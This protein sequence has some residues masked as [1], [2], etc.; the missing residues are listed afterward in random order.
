MTCFKRGQIIVLPHEGTDISAL[1]DAGIR[2]LYSIGDIISFYRTTR[3]EQDREFKSANDYSQFYPKVLQVKPGQEIS[4]AEWLV[5]HGLVDAAAPNYL[6]TPSAAQEVAPVAT[7]NL[8]F[9]RAS[10]RGMAAESSPM[11]GA[12]VTVA[13]LDTGVDPTAIPWPC[14]VSQYQYDVNDPKDLS[15]FRPPTDRNGHGTLLAGIISAIVPAATIHSVKVSG[16]QGTLAGVLAGINLAEEFF[17]PDIINM[18]FRIH[19]PPPGSEISYAQTEFMFK[20][21]LRRSRAGRAADRPLVIACAGNNEAEV[22]APASFEGVLAVGAF[23]GANGGPEGY[24]RYRSLPHHRFIRAPGGADGDCV[25]WARSISGGV[26]Q[27]EVHFGTSFAAAFAS[28][29][30]AR[31]ACAL[32]GGACSYP[33][34]RDIIGWEFVLECLRR[35]ARMPEVASEYEGWGNL[36]Y[37]LSAV[38]R[39]RAAWAEMDASSRCSSQLLLEDAN[40]R[41]QAI[42]RHAYY[43]AERR[44]F[45]PGRELEDWVEAERLFTAATLSAV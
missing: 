31:Y 43:R 12:D 10:L 34:G 27:S 44:G 8:E 24:S 40:Y 33:S 38:E 39:I 23:A 26:A 37:D 42:R 3:L 22:S 11:C 5:S 15:A 36:F 45:T 28:G 13:L 9:L 4:T 30:A 29:I 41:D 6:V 19:A 18:S 21:F 35:S 20:S 1:H 17:Q 7:F 14:K 2:F 32:R 25:G 16:D